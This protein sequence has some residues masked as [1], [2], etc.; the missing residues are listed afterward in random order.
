MQMRDFPTRCN[1]PQNECPAIYET[2]P[3]VEVKRYNRHVTKHLHL[4]FSRLDIH[5]R[6]VCSPGPDLRKDMFEVLLYFNPSVRAVRNLSGI[7]D[8]RI[9]GECIPKL[10]PI[11][12]VKRGDE[13][14]QESANFIL[15]TAARARLRHQ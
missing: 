14:G 5:V 1:F 3:V 4:K 7:E 11:Q 13:F 9:I 15:A 12:I 2:R 10:L 8:R 6:S